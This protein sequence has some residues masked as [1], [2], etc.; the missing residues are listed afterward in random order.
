[1]IR[2]LAT[3]VLFLG[4]AVPL[5][6]QEE[7]AEDKRFLERKLQEVLSGAGREV[8]ISG[9]RGA[10]SSRARLERMTI[11]DSQGVWLTLR[12]A[13]L[14]WTRSALLA[15]RLKIDALRAAEIE[16]ARTPVPE[17]GLAPADAA[18]TP[19]ALPEL[20][21]SVNIG[22][23]EVARIALAPALLGEAVTLSAAGNLALSGGEGAAQLD[24]RRM[25]REDRLVLD[26]AFSNETRILALDLDFE[27]AAGGLV[28][29]LLGIPGAPSLGLQIEGDAPLSDY[30]AQIALS[31]DGAPRLQGA[32]TVRADGEDAGGHV[33][34]A[35][36]DGD[37]RPLFAAEFHPFFGARTGLVARV[38][39]PADGRTLLDRLEI[40]SEGLTLGGTMALDAGGWPERFDLEGRL[41]DG[42]PLRL[43][44]SGAA[45]TLEQA[46]FTARYDRASGDRWTADIRIDALKRDA[47]SIGEA[48]LNGQGRITRGL[49]ASGPFASAGAS[50]TGALDFALTAL[51]P[52]DA[53]LRRAIGPSPSGRTSFEWRPDA[54]FAIE[55]LALQSGDMSLTA[56]ATVDAL[57]DGL[58]LR[59]DVSLRAG[60][61]SRFSGLAGRDLAG[62]AIAEI[63]GEVTPLSGAFDILVDA[64]TQGLRTGEPRLDPL[65]RGETRL[66]LSAQRD[67]AGIRLRSLD[68]NNAAATITASGLLNGSSGLLEATAALTDIAL[69]EPKLSGDARAQ[70]QVAW[71]DGAPLRL[72]ALEAR[73]GATTLAASG[74][75]DP[76]DAVL[77]AEGNLRLVSPDLSRLAA[78]LGRPLAG[79]LE[80]DLSGAAQLRGDA[81]D[82]TFDVDGTAVRSG[83]SALDRLIAG[84]LSLAGSAALTAQ[85]LD[86]RYF[87]FSSPQLRANVAGAGPGQPVNLS[88]RLSD[89]ALLTDSVSGPAEI[90]GTVTLTDRLARNFAVALDAKGPGGLG[91]RLTGNVRDYG[92][93]LS[94][95]AAGS[96]PLQLA[97]RFI[98]P[99]SVAGDVSFDLA[100]DGAPQTGSISG[101]ASFAE[102][103]VSLPGEAMVLDDLTGEITLAGGSAGL[104]LSGG[105]GQG[106][107]FEVSGPIA[108]APPF[109]ADLAIRLLRLVLSDPEL[110]ETRLN[111]DLGING[112]LT[113]GAR[114]AGAINLGRTELRIPSGSGA[115]IGTLPELR[116]LSEPADV[117][118]TRRR[119]GLVTEAGNGGGGPGFPLDLTID[120]PNQIF[121]RGRGLDAELGGSIRLAGSTN[122]VIPSGVFELIRGRIDILGKRLDLTEG[123]IDLRGA[124]DPYLRFL[125]ETTAGDVVVQI[126]LEGLASAPTVTFESVPE[127]P[128]EEVVARLIFGRGLDNISAFQAAQLVSAVGQ[129]TGRFDG[130]VVGDLRN[131]LGLSDLDISTNEDGATQVRA[132]AYIADNVYSE[133]MAD[134]DGK[135][136]INLNLDVTP[137][138]TLRGR[139]DTEGETGLGVFFERDY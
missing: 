24:I 19:F 38:G 134:S 11:S 123:L 133:V 94:L 137:N 70:A 132:G 8:S 96:A 4:L 14:I 80:L 103:R 116:H 58:P 22:Q 92:Q 55:D 46:D 7:E 67:A 138:L 81:F 118:A 117:N 47:L 36:I 5:A 97:N 86:L 1:M 12:D 90:R 127:L 124:L 6:A 122:A 54:P 59:G 71:Q 105:A 125:G 45:I 85:A 112:P 110:F 15:G 23:L 113:G 82:M 84:D 13:E 126:L 68:L 29:G 34:A 102:A 107:R 60:N 57:A 131:A 79:R 35:D 40:A 49:L 39:L 73:I 41:G 69:V 21:V 95:R 31:S 108:L 104:S 98:S 62:A 76:E 48:R 32:V 111:G 2:I 52:G 77:P 72:S 30:D 53:D 83:I 115:I 78:L 9:F 119:A 89:L 37:V 28:S 65:L 3:L 66:D 75:I 42:T 87:K 130:G 128:Q 114:I 139:A 64:R 51:D 88:A 61:I 44:A 109:R 18:A 43:P 106:G 26:G 100:V 121:V 16:I 99:R 93:A 74:E 17:Q 50:V 136:Q 56:E 101:Q 27:E 63:T 129:L 91:A 135:Q 120:A 25:D 10:L 20:P 33:I